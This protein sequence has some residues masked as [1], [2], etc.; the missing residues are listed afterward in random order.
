[1]FSSAICFGIMEVLCFTITRLRTSTT[2]NV[3]AFEWRLRTVVF[4]VIVKEGNTNISL[5]RTGVSLS[6]N[7][8]S[9]FERTV[10]GLW[11]GMLLFGRDDIMGKRDLGDIKFAG[12]T[13]ETV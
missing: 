9:W 1:M 11:R 12:P 7:C 6:I 10:L 8:R 4:S 13:K 2:Q 3:K 5:S